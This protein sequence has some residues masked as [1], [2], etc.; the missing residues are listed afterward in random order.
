MSVPVAPDQLEGGGRRYR[1]WAP[2]PALR[3]YVEAFWVH[4]VPHLLSDFR[5]LPDGRMGIVWRA[6]VGAWATGPKSSFLKHPPTGPFLALGAR[7]RPGAGPAVL[8][9]AASELRDGHVALGDLDPVFA[10][11][12]QGGLD[13]ARFEHEALAVFNDE[14]TRR[15]YESPQLDPVVE[16]AVHLLADSSIAV[17]DVADRV[18]VSERQ[19]QRRFH[20]GI[21]YG[22]KTLQRILRFQDAVER[23]R[24]GAGPA[25]AAASAGYADQSHL[26]RESRRLAG[27]SPRELVGAG[28]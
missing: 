14:L 9:V 13:R 23:L 3:P 12:L 27:L 16:E 10:R 17:A 22:P 8:G 24:A 18:F 1:E 5:L 15:V 28:H 11:R 21:G 4:E 20:E 6:G 19:L 26:F 2:A 25:R 7:F